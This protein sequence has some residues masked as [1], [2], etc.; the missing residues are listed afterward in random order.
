MEFRTSCLSVP[1][2]EMLIKM[3]PK[4]S[5]LCDV[6]ECVV[7]KEIKEAKVVEDNLIATSALCARVSDNRIQRTIRT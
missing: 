7:D 5:C 1:E 4:R 6:C 3:Q 2:E